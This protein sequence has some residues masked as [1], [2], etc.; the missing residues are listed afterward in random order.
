MRHL[1]CLNGKTP[2]QQTLIVQGRVHAFYLVIMTEA[3]DF[4]FFFSFLTFSSR[5]HGLTPLTPFSLWGLCCN[6]ALYVV[7]LHYTVIF[8]TPSWVAWCIN[9][10]AFSFSP[11]PLSLISLGLYVFLFH[12]FIYI[13]FFLMKPPFC[14]C[15]KSWKH[16][17]GHAS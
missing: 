2:E 3:G 11:F 16:M 13:Y 6:G 8:S 14:K 12:L 10:F 7:I 17:C 1:M 5:S 15:Q 4:F 9:L